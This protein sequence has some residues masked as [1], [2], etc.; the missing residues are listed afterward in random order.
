MQLIK[1]L[2]AR[3]GL[4]EIEDVFM[5]KLAVH[6]IISVSMLV[7]IVNK[8]RQLRY[9]KLLVYLCSVALLLSLVGVFD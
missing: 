5:I 7:W 2:V 1:T 9:H 3:M 4:R 8:E 6:V